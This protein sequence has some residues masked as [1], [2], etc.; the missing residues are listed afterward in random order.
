MYFSINYMTI[1][2]LDRLSSVI[3]KGSSVALSLSKKEKKDT[4]SSWIPLK[5]YDGNKM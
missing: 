2:S 3:G 4:F 1:P 5:N